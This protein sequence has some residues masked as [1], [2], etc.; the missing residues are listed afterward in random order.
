MALELRERVDP[1]AAALPSEGGPEPDRC[2]FSAARVREDRTRCE[3]RHECRRPLGP[4]GADAALFTRAQ[5]PV[6]VSTPLTT[7]STA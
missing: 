2:G 1:L 5:W 6:S 4:A 3:T 7:S